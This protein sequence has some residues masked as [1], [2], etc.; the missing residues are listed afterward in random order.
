MRKLTAVLLGLALILPAGCGEAKKEPPTLY[1]KGLAVV[2][3][4]AGELNGEYVGYFTSSEIAKLAE[5]LAEQ[6]YSDPLCV[7]ELK[8]ADSGL[9]RFLLGI[10][11]E[12][13]DIPQEVMDRMGGFT[14][15]ANIINV[16]KGTDYLALSSILT[17]TELFVNETVTQDAAYL[18]F[19]EDA[20]P[21]LVS[22]QAGE[23]GAVYAV[24]SFVFSDTL[25]ERGTG[26]LDE[27][28]EDFMMFS[29]ALEITQVTE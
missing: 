4:L 19:Y 27:L 14:Y 23:D 2:A 11:G 20:Y 17:A 9:K 1:D 8:Y 16:R 29:G 13:G 5:E 18:Y 3:A 22:Y 26:G 6:D 12:D 25:K 21:V 7:Y 24:G 10:T 28:S 15:L